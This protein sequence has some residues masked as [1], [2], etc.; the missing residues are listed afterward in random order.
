[1]WK[2]FFQPPHSNIWGEFDRYD[3]AILRPFGKEDHERA[4]AH[5]KFVLEQS[6]IHWKRGM[7]QWDELG[8][9]RQF[10]FAPS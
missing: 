1:M 9:Q 3:A 10:E 4:S 6:L 7:V 2:I 5:A 8:E